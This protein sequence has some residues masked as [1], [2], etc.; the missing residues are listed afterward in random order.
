VRVTFI[1]GGTGLV[2]G[3]MIPRILNDD[4]DGIVKVLVRAAD[5]G[6]ADARLDRALRHLFKEADLPRAR[7]RVSALA[8]DLTAPGLGLSARDAGAL[9]EEVTHII[10][11]AATTRFDLPYA[12][13]FA[14]NVEGT[15]RVLDLARRAAPGRLE[16]Y[17]H[18]S[19]AYVSGDRSGAIREEDLEAGQGFVNSYERTKHD[20][21]REVRRAMGEMP[22]TV[23]RPCAVIGD[24]GTG[25][26]STFNVIYYPL[27]LLS[28]GLLRALPGS[29]STP[30]DL[31]PVDYVADAM[32]HLLLRPDSVGRTYHLTAGGRV[33]S[34]G[35]IAELAVKHLNAQRGP[36]LTPLPPVRFIP[37]G[38]FHGLVKPFLKLLYG[39]RGR[40]VIAKLEVYLPYLTTRKH[41]DTSGAEA[42]LRGTGIG[43]PP[44]ADYFGR[45][46][47]YCLETDWGRR[48]PA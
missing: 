4:A 5:A 3:E 37:H 13:A 17:L 33:E 22:V 27:K 38:I 35:T 20:A 34:I 8:G 11:S 36:E 28:R 45:V 14:V 32:N 19:T 31:V 48:S 15:R 10:H 25:R 6:E 43:V 41:F 47:R 9:A 39:A 7:R 2:G 30:I 40:Q 1:T 21:E 18:V 12:E 42:A 16:R 26:T 44:L 29:P 24:S 46:V 23:V